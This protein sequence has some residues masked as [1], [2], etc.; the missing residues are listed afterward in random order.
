MSGTKAASAWFSRSVP[1]IDA[2][3]RLFCFPYAGG[4]TSI[5]HSWPGKLPP[6][7]EVCAIQLPGRG[8]RLWEKPF[9]QMPALVSALTQELSDFLDRPFA[10]FGHSMGALIAFELA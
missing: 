7:V 1:R 3:V 4:G 5:F 6:G 9:S 10:F 2:S 8:R